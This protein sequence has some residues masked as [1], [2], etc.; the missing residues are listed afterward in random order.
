MSL[1]RTLLGLSEGCKNRIWEGLIRNSSVIGVNHTKE[2]TDCE[3]SGEKSKLKS[4]SINDSCSIDGT[5]QSNKRGRKQSRCQ[6]IEF[7]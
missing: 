7:G 4:E 1:T 5:N 3:E 2:N 6:K